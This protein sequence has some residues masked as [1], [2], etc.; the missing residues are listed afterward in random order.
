VG[1][2]GLA[3]GE[4]V[5]RFGEGLDEALIDASLGELTEFGRAAHAEM[6]A[7]LDAVRRGVAV[8]D[9][10]LYATTFPCHNCA[11]HI[12]ASGIARVVFIEPYEKSRAIELHRDS[13]VLEK[14]EVG[15]VTFE[16]FVGVA[17]RRYLLSF[18]QALR[19]A[20]GHLP[21]KDGGAR[22]DFKKKSARP[23]FA[24]LEPPELQP[25][26]PSYR[27]KELIALERFG[28][29][30]EQHGTIEPAPEPPAPT[31]SSRNPGPEA[32][33]KGTSAETAKVRPKK[34]SSDTRKRNPKASE[35]DK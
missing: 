4:V 13:A 26:L 21:R 23:V 24:D 8:R 15:K 14:P 3:A 19:I 9:A 34:N 12:I 22:V 17:P 7:L 27:T 2:A 31:R 11:R 5:N 35:R 10:T 25:A 33:R 29:L 32:G 18:D 20:L 30:T 28:E 1:P 6:D 16:H